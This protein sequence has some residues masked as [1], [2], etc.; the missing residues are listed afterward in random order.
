[1]FSTMNLRHLRYFA[2]LARERHHGR[3][4]EA[5]HVT[6]PTLS[7]AIRQLETE[8]GTPLIRREGVRMTG[9]TEA[10]ERVLAFAQRMMTEQDTLSQ[11]LSALRDELSGE[12]RIGSIPA[13]IGI[14]PVLTTG[15]HARHAGVA[16]R[17]LSKTSVEISQGLA[18]GDL[19]AGLTYLDN[20]PLSGV[21]AIPLYVE[22]LV[23]LTPARG[24][25]ADAQTARWQDAAASPALP[26]HAGHAE[27]PDHRCRVRAVWRRPA[28]YRHRGE[29]DPGAFGPCEAWQLVD[30]R[31]AALRFDARR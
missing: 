5:C 27:P 31:A 22:H 8:V 17:V 30:D 23:L 12:L 21:E 20:E 7:G 10:G 19:E 25:F 13:A 6:Q 24:S 28:E 14:V 15:F 3:A 26:P 2:A 9:L 4:A 18:A 1:M 11:Q 29:L 16:I